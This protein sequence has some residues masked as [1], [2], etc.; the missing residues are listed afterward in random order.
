MKD[1][2]MHA[3]NLVDLVNER[4]ATKMQ[5]IVKPQMDANYLI[6]IENYK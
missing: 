4:F 3:T 2:I 6:K 1:A 5:R